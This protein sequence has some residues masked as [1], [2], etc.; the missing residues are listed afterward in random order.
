MALLIDRLGGEKKCFSI[1][2]ASKAF[3]LE[4]DEKGADPIEL[5]AQH[6]LT[7]VHVG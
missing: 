2:V 4:C 6:F 3:L 7:L 1:T 5:G